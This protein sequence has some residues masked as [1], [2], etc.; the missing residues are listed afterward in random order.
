VKPLLAA[1]ALDAYPRLVNLEVEHSLGAYT[2]IANTELGA[3]FDA[4]RLYPGTRVPFSAFL[5]AS[6]NVFAATLGFLA[7]AER[8][9]GGLPSRHG[10]SNESHMTVDGRP[11]AGRPAWKTKGGRMSIGES[12]FAASLEKLYA[13]HAV[14]KDAPVIDDRFWKAAVDKGYMRGTFELQRITP[15]P[16]ILRLEEVQAPRMLA[17][18]MIGG[19]TDRWNN[20]GMTEAVS[21]IFTG[22]RIDLHLLRAIGEDTLYTTPDSLP[23]MA[24][25]R[26]AVLDGMRGVVTLPYA[27]A[28][29]L[30]TEFGATGLDWVGKTGTLKERDWTGS[31]FLFAGASKG[32]TSTICAAAG[33]LTIEFA[34]GGDP[35]GKATAFFSS[36]IAPLLRQELG[37][38]DK[39]CRAR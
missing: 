12:P 28:G 27:T 36:A 31:L 2:T 34:N 25:V 30:R 24:A 7:A 1:A 15:E 33:V 19:G 38:G 26:G 3:P 16:V 8:G 37:W 11:L 13:V 22:R 17:T 10:S 35:D 23:G 14:A 9:D 6:D 4:H 18:F 5:P 29:A 32:Q 21:R 20:V 39:P